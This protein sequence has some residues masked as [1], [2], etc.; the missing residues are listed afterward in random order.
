MKRYDITPVPK[1]RQTQS[2]RW[3]QR[4]PVMRYRAYKDHVR[5]LGIEVKPTGSR[6]L[7]VLSMPKSWSKKKRREMFGQPHQGKPDT[8]NLVKG[9][10]DAIHVD[11]QHLF[12]IEAYKF[13]GESG[14]I[15]IDDIPEVR[16]FNGAQLIYA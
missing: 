8:D 6:I 15:I 7:F 10:W 3:K 11:D 14:A 1:P 12:H 16:G 4:A 2:D 9:L 5:A 13:W